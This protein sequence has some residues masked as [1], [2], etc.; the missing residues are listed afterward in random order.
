M[1]LPNGWRSYLRDRTAESWDLAASM[2]LSWGSIC[3]QLPVPDVRAGGSGGCPPFP[4][5][6]PFWLSSL[7]SSLARLF[8]I[9]ES[10]RFW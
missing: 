6:C 10:S 3:Y 2:Y 1:G 5:P 7:L 9:S 8:I 4:I